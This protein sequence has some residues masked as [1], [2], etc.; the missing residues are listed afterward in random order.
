MTL[1]ITLVLASIWIRFTTPGPGSFYLM[2]TTDSL[3]YR[4]E[5]SDYSPTACHAALTLPRDQEHKHFF[6]IFEPDNTPSLL[7]DGGSVEEE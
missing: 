4:V 3:C 6:V 5:M 2:S 1:T 7:N